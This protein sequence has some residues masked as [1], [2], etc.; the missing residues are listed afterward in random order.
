MSKS[1]EHLGGNIIVL[2]N[3]TLDSILVATAVIHEKLDVMADLLNKIDVLSIDD[4]SSTCKKIQKIIR[5]FAVARN[6]ANAA[7]KIL[8]NEFG[9]IRTHCEEPENQPKEI[10]K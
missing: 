7:T 2:S 3:E 10:T 8:L 1:I 4:D 5:P 9:N 6:R